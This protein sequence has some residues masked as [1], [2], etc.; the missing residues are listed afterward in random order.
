MISS[1]FQLIFFILLTLLTL[2]AALVPRLVVLPAP[3]HQVAQLPV[4]LM[5]VHTV[6]LVLIV[7]LMDMLALILLVMDTTTMERSRTLKCTAMA[8]I[9]ARAL[10]QVQ[11]EKIRQTNL[12]HVSSLCLHTSWVLQQ[13]PVVWLEQCT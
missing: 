3:T 12:L 1:F 4:T 10:A 2:T 5:L 13:L 8:L 11:T 7:V 9:R 6:T